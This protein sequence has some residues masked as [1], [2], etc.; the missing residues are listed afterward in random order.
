[1]KQIRRTVIIILTIA[2][3]FGILSDVAYADRCSDAVSYLKNY[4]ITN[5]KVTSFYNQIIF[6]SYDGSQVCDSSMFTTEGRIRYSPETDTI[7]IDGSML[8]HVQITLD[9]K[10]KESKCYLITPSLQEEVIINHAAVTATTKLVFSNNKG[11]EADRV[12]EYEK[13]VTGAFHRAMIVLNRILKT[14]GY[15][16]KD[17]G[18]VKYQPYTSVCQYLNQCPGHVFKDM[19]SGGNW[20]HDPIDWAVKNRI[21]AGTSSTMFS[22]GKYCTRGQ[23]VTFLWRANGCPKVNTEENP[24]TDVSEDSYYYDAVLWAISNGITNG[25]SAATFSPELVCTRAHVVTFLYRAV[26][27]PELGDIER[28]FADVPENAFYSDAVNWAVS[29]EITTGTGTLDGKPL[30]SPESGCTRAQVVTFLYR[31][32]SF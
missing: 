11:V 14:G 18:F 16:L 15:N 4:L 17:L 9:P 27:N 7:F 5:G 13:F 2:F 25:T 19:P 32:Y 30:F 3:T 10:G 26:K 6:Y 20:A 22:P 31:A 28:H 1:M 21:T 29:N 8:H 24:F 12:K 23:I